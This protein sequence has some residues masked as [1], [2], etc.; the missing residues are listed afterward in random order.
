[1]GRDFTYID[2]IVESIVRLRL[3]PPRPVEG[4]PPC[5]L[6]NIGR[7]QPVRLLHFVDCLEDALG[8]KAQ[9]DYLPLQAGD[10]LETWADVSSLTRWIDFSPGTSLE[11]GVNAFVGWYRGFYRV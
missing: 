1:M 8:I 11:H 7:G 4:K 6:F 9:R 2:D 10:V 3:K 5:Q